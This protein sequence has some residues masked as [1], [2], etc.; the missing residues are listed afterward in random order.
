MWKENWKLL[1]AQ[2]FAKAFF[3]WV[4]ARCNKGR[5]ESHSLHT[6]NLR[7]PPPYIPSREKNIG[8]ILDISRSWNKSR[9][10]SALRKY[11]LYGVYLDK[12]SCGSQETAW[13]TCLQSFLGRRD[14]VSLGPQWKSMKIIF[15]L[16]TN[17]VS[18]LIVDQ[19]SASRTKQS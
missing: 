9:I 3:R 6:A 18:L 7:V 8:K 12:L 1:R 16:V 17:L 11:I 5:D 10:L 19:P 13:K 2:K 14:H 4:L 15:T